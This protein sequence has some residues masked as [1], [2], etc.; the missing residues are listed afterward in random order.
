MPGI[1]DERLEAERARRRPSRR[2]ARPRRPR[3]APPR[4]SRTR[5]TRRARAPRLPPA[6]TPAKTP[7][8]RSAICARS[9]C[10]TD[11]S[12]RT[13][14]RRPRVQRVD[15]PLR[16]RRPHPRPAAREAVRQQEHRR[17]DHVVGRGRALRD[18]VLADQPA[19]HTRPPP[20]P[21]PPP[22]RLSTPTAVR[23]AVDRVA[24]RQR[25]FDDCPRLGHPRPRAGVQRDW[26]AP[27]R[28]RDDRVAARGTG[29]RAR[30]SRAARPTRSRRC[31]AEPHV[32]PTCARSLRGRRALPECRHRC[33]PSPSPRVAARVSAPI[34]AGGIAE[35]RVRDGDL[36]GPEPLPWQGFSFGPSAGRTVTRPPDP[37][38]RKDAP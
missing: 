20:R 27:A 13:A 19:R 15:Q 14:R 2:R 17:P 30:R 37:S 34:M 23:R 31:I 7:A 26:R 38:P 25:T 29:R 3:P 22:T 6:A 1:R 5:W 18:P 33:A 8:A 35:G 32:A 21:P 16:Q 9:A 24:A 36:L 28:D 4:R 11:P 12:V 10:P